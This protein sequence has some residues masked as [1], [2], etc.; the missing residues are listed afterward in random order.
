[1]KFSSEHF[2]FLNSRDVTVSLALSEWVYWMCVGVWMCVGCVD[3]CWMCV[4]VWGVGAVGLWWH[5]GWVGLQYHGQPGADDHH[6]TIRGDV[7]DRCV[8]AQGMVVAAPR[9]QQC[10]HRHQRA[11]LKH[12]I[13][14]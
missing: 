6:A 14:N 7:P 8:A 10:A 1:M 11:H 5:A 9:E 13:H 2:F 4:G 12:R 3:V